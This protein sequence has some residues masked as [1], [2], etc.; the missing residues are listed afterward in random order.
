MPSDATAIT[1][2]IGPWLLPLSVAILVHVAVSNFGASDLGYNRQVSGYMIALAGAMLGVFAFSGRRLLVDTTLVRALLLFAASVAVSVWLAPN[3]LLALNRLHLYVAALLLCLGI[4]GF[5]SDNERFAWHL[6]RLLLAMAA[7][8]LWFVIEVTFWS[9][10]SS[11][12]PNAGL[13]LPNYSNIRHFAYHGYIAAASA[14]ALFLV[15]RQFKATAW[16]CASV[17][18]FGIAL[19]GARGAVVAWG[20]TLLAASLMRGKRLGLF[21]FAS[22]AAAAALAVLFYLSEA[23]LILGRSLFDRV[24]AGETLRVSD[25][26]ELWV[27]AAAAVPTSPWF[28]FGPDGYSLSRCCSPRF[29][30]PH[31]L[32]LQFLLEFGIVGCS[33]LLASVAALIRCFGGGI[34]LCRAALDDPSTQ[35]VG[36]VL[37]GFLAYAGIDGLLF[38]AVPVAHF[39]VLMALFL[40]SLRSA[41]LIDPIQREEQF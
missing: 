26:I 14:T 11:L 33:L 37:A 1:A 9:I 28:G 35:A 17:A 31:N 4:Y 6:E 8:H 18:L 32:I 30:Q 27:E 12:D 36:A 29:E 24:A 38:H 2:R 40:G 19:T 22:T 39:A 15:S 25:R 20:I 13:R 16:V 7:V 23:D 41:R 5:L 3:P 10:A 21:V 34:A